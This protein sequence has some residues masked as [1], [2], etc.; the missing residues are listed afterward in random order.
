MTFDQEAFL[1]QRYGAPSSRW[2]IYAAFFAVIFGSWLLWSANH[3]AHPE[4]RSSLISFNVSS[5][6]SVDIRYSLQL[7]HPNHSHY[8]TLVAR[9]F[10][11]NVVGEIR[12]PIPPGS[13]RLIRTVTIPTRTKAVN[14]AVLACE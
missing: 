3:A 7:A 8:C 11:K 9:D 2:K 5:N 6:S 10:Q 4:I 13:E 12:D 1:K 14:A